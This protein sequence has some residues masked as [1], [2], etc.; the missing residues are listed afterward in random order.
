MQPA[1]RNAWKRPGWDELDGRSIMKT[2][3][4][5]LSPGEG[6]MKNIN[7]TE[8]PVS[9]WALASDSLRVAALL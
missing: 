4:S 5:I 3:D 1:V 8:Q 7:S 6:F 2:E 9:L